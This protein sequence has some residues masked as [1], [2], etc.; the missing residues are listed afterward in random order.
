MNDIP[1]NFLIVG[2]AKAGTTSIHEYLKQHPDIFMS[3]RKEPCF[4]TFY[5][6]SPPSYSTDRPVEFIHDLDE[7]NKLFDGSG[8]YK[9]RGESST[10]YLFFYEKTIDNIKRLIPEYHLLNILIV[11]RNPID[12]AY[13]QYMMKI[14]DVVENLS[15]EDAVKMESSRE[16]ENAHFDFFYTKRGFYKEQV[17]AYLSNFKNVK[18]L[19]YDDF[20][21]NESIFLNEILDFLDVKKYDFKKIEKENVSGV[22]KI[23]LVNNF[24]LSPSPITKILAYFV[25]NNTKKILK[26]IIMKHNNANPPKIGVQIREELKQLYIDDIKELEHIINKDLSAWYK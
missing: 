17:K 9:I 23:R 11:L 15:F 22:P 8:D 10:P 19:L 6:E 7:Y 21:E 25:S 20:K 4:F 26:K 2:A 24:L 12:R 16:K 13:S 18:I 14:R 1:T 5:N 3:E